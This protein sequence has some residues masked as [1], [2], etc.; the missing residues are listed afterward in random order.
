MFDREGKTR[1]ECAHST[2]KELHKRER[3]QKFERGDRGGA[4]VTTAK[5]QELKRTEID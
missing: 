1:E 2:T 4:A 3:S 5:L